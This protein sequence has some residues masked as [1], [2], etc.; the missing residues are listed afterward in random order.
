MPHIS[1][2]IYRTIYYNCCLQVAEGKLRHAEISEQLATSERLVTSLQ[3]KD[4][5][6][7]QLCTQL[8]Q[9]LVVVQLQ[10][11]QQQQQA[12]V[13]AHHHQQEQAQRHAQE[14]LAKQQEQE[15]Q[16]RQAAK[17]EEEEE[18]ACLLAGAH[19]GSASRC[20]LPVRVL[21]RLLLYAWVPKDPQSSR[22]G[23]QT[24]CCVLWRCM[25]GGIVEGSEWCDL[26]VQV[27]P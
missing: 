20:D 12:Q 27:L 16:V 14:K 9:K 26:L 4:S 24:M 13:Q 17:E 22:K 19:G 18:E 6:T 1:T 3:Q 7:Q 15:Q 21:D 5:N 10:Q 2:L 8:Q 23:E 11:E 25:C